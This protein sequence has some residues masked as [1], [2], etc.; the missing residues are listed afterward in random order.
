MPNPR[1]RHGRSR[2]GKRRAH[3]KLNQPQSVPCE[4]CGAP[5]LRHRVCTAC[6]TYKKKAVVEVAPTES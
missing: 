3:Y 4:S 5:K 6:G 2:Q 1:R